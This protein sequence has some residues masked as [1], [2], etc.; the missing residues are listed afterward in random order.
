MSSSKVNGDV[1]AVQALVA[2]ASE[3]GHRLTS[4]QVGTCRIELAAA[5]GR[6]VPTDPMRMDSPKTVYETFGGEVFREAHVELARD[7]GLDGLQ[8]ALRSE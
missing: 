8:P 1:A 6:A 4:V 7:L 3:H 5:A 2:W